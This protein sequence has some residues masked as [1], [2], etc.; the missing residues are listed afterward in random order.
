MF[1]RYIQYFSL[2]Q[3]TFSFVLRSFYVLSLHILS[4]YPSLSSL[5]LRLNSHL[6]NSIYFR[7]T[8]DSLFESIFT[9]HR[10]IPRSP[11][12]IFRFIFPYLYL[13]LSLYACF[14]CRLAP[15]LNLYTSHRF[16]V[17]RYI[18]FSP[19]LFYLILL[20]TFL[21]VSS[22]VSFP[23]SIFFSL[24]PFSSIAIIAFK[25]LFI[26]NTQVCERR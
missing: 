21:H 22:L 26:R 18:F 16:M 7:F 23:P 4:V 2:Y 5:N 3:A 6:I 17:N 20:S 9:S 25:S 19:S 11:S 15:P 10:F 24:C 8:I 13:S 12:C 14:F 1:C